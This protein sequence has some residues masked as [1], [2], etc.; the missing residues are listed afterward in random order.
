MGSASKYQLF[1]GSK[2]LLHEYNLETKLKTEIVEVHPHENK[3]TSRRGHR[4]SF[5]KLLIATESSPVALDVS[6]KDLPGVFT[7]RSL[8]DSEKIGERADWWVFK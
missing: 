6:G 1:E 7:V 4:F 5:D 3:I 8:E 2:K